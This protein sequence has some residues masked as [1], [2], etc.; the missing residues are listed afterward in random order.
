[1]AFSPGAGQVWSGVTPLPGYVPERGTK[2]AG[3]LQLIQEILVGGKEGEGKLE[4][5]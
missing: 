2:E 1:M 4:T 3:K 5:V